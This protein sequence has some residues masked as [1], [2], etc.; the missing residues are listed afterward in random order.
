MC[1]FLSSIAFKNGDIHH[2]PMTD[3]HEDLIDELGL[4]DISLSTRN[5]VR[6]EY[7]ADDLADIKKYKINIDESVKPSWC[8]KE[9]VGNLEDKAKEIVKVIILKNVEKKILVGG[10]WILTGGSIIDRV[11]NVRI[12]LMGSSKVGVMR[13]SSNVGEMRGSSKVGVMMGSSKV[14]EMMGSSNVGEMW[15]SSNVG[16]MMGSSN[17]GVMRGSSNVGEMMGSSNVGVMMESSNVG[18]MRESSNVNKDNRI[19]PATVV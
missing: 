18:V 16:V 15:G 7:A 12:I 6:F 5:W 17:V 14:G 1:R 11:V 19:K 3:S 13:E 10:C 2:N 9:Y 8:D 4:K